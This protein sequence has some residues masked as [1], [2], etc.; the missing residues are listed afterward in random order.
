MQFAINFGAKA[1]SNSIT[2]SFRLQEHSIIFFAKL[3]KTNLN[4]PFLKTPIILI[5]F[6]GDFLYAQNTLSF[7]NTT[8]L[9]LPI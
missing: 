1:N 4:K 6:F 5:Y 7:Q 9:L 3:I 2:N 8:I